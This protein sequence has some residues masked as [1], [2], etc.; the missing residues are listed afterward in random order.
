V[1]ADFLLYEDYI[2]I[3]TKII[4]FRV[5]RSRGE[6]HIGHGCLCAC[7]SVPRRIHTLLHGPGYRPN[8][9]NGRGAL[10][11]ALLCGF[12]IGSRVSLAPNAKCQ[13]VLV[14]ALCLVIL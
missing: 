13:Q 8:V 14:L 1:T 12:A 10:S 4:T 9:G 2:K 5:R 11:Y 6:M 7:L 3:I